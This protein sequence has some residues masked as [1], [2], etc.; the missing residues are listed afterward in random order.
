VVGLAEVLRRNLVDRPVD[1]VVSA[2]EDWTLQDRLA[3]AVVTFAS[4]QER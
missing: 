3:D 2:L 4:R 1:V